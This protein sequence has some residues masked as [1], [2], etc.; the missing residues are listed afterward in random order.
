M[1]ELERSLERFFFDRVRLNGGYAIKLV[2]TEKGVPDRLVVFPGPRLFLVELKTTT[3]KLSPIQT[4]WHSMVLRR[5]GLQVVVLYGQEQV[6]HWVAAV[7]RTQRA[8]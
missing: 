5:F 6:I 2:A 7:V 4:Y 3:G 1:T 8:S